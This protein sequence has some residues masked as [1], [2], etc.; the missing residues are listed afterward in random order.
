MHTIGSQSA[1][2]ASYQFDFT[3]CLLFESVVTVRNC[4]RLMR[5]A[6]GR[7][8]RVVIMALLVCTQEKES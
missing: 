2:Y 4:R 3:M 5:I 8:A 1:Q 6:P 7:K